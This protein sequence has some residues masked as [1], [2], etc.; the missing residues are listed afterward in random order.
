MLRRRS[1]LT[2]LASV[3]AVIAL[4]GCGPSKPNSASTG[5]GALISSPTERAAYAGHAVFPQTQ[6]IN[7]LPVAAIVSR[8]KKQL[9]LYNFGKQAIRNVDIWVNGSF[10]TRI[11]GIAPQSKV[12][13]GTNDIF[14]GLGHSLASRGEEVSRVQLDDAGRLYNLMGPASE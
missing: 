8:D 4:T 13:I 2:T 14:N 1:T 5:S 3:A 7:E 9:N 12:M 11:G 10:V 6:P